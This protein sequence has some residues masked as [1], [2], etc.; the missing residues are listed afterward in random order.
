M[1]IHLISPA[2]HGRYA[3]VLDLMF[4]MRH[5]FYVV[6]RGWK[7]L[8]SDDGRERDQFDDDRAFYFVAFDDEGRPIV[9]AR[10][11]PTDDGSL[12]QNLFPHLI[13]PG[14]TAQYGPDVW[15]L[16]RFFVAAD[17]RGPN[18]RRI[19]E[20]LRIAMFEA[21]LQNGVR[22]I[23]LVCDTFFLSTLRTIGWRFRHL[24]LPAAYDE[25]EAMA[26]E[27]CCEP[28]DVAAMRERSGIETPVLFEVDRL[29]IS[30][31][32]PPL[33]AERFLRLL[34]RLP[35]GRVAE[36]RRRVEALLQA[37]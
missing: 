34:D 4:Q 14:E 9:S 3:D 13:A 7:A 33:E 8:K 2:V 11:R 18:G 24:G 21:A 26:V 17:W 37:H 19:R 30:P 20:A 6:E 35:S 22:R 16:T 27:I 28:Q 31:D 29:P 25:G 15:E 5:D 23:N 12:L 36:L 32:L 10:M 1:M